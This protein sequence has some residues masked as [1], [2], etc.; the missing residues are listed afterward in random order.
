MNTNSTWTDSLSIDEVAPSEVKN[1][2]N[3]IN[4]ILLDL[5][6]NQVGQLRKKKCCG[7]E[8]NHLSQK[9]RDCL[10]MT[11]DEGWIMHGLEAIER[12]NAQDILWKEFLEAIH[13]MKLTYH[14]QALIHYTNLRK[15]HKATIHLLMDLRK[16]STLLEYEPVVNYLSYWIAEHSQ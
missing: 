5:I 2:C 3:L 4:A 7:C 15:D 8:V 10:M 9:R 14:K 11:V 1:L 16:G 13:V 6:A 12:I